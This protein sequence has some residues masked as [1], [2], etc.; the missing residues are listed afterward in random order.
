M[1]FSK[2][3]FFFFLL[4]F[5][6]LSFP[7]ELY[8]R[9]GLDSNNT[10]F[11]SKRKIIVNKDEVVQ[12]LGFFH[13]LVLEP[14]QLS[15]KKDF[16]QSIRKL[17]TK[18]DAKDLR[19]IITAEKQALRDDIGIKFIAGIRESTGNLN[20]YQNSAYAGISWDIAKDGY[21]E[22]RLQSEELTMR[23]SIDAK[24]G[25][26]SKRKLLSLYRQNFVAYY[27]ARQKIPILRKKIKVLDELMRV[28]REGYFYGVELADSLVK[29]ER[30]IEKSKAELRQYKELVYAYCNIERLGFCRYQGHQLPPVLSVKF[31]RVIREM[32]HS[33]TLNEV[34]NLRAGNRIIRLKHDWRHNLKLRAYLYYNTKGDNSFFDKNGLVG[35]VN[36]SYPLSKDHQD[37]DRLRLIHNQNVLE[38]KRVYLENYANLLYREEEEKVS[39]AVKIWYGMDIAFERIR[40][41]SIRLHNE[42]EKGTVNYR[43]YLALVENIKEF[44]DGEYEFVASEELLYRRIANLLTM[45]GVEWKGKLGEVKLTP[46]GNRFRVGNRYVIIKRDDVTKLSKNF[47]ANLLYTKKIEN[48]IMGKNLFD[49]KK[50]R[51]I[52]NA[53]RNF[54]IKVYLLS[55]K[56]SKNLQI[57]I[58]LETENLN[59]ISGKQQCIIFDG[60]S[61][62]TELKR[63]LKKTDILFVP[64][65]DASIASEKLGI[66]IKLN[67]TISELELEKMLD[68]IYHS[69]IKNFLFDFGELLSVYNGGSR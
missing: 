57:P 24:K 20:L 39:D 37:V 16:I 28:K 19:K 38:S 9:Y 6:G 35:G 27:F 67:H 23:Q 31:R 41:E 59:E 54:G 66:I 8:C 42:L 58:C 63:Y 34:K 61:D 14:L 64:Q 5:L 51:A 47:L 52:K 30:E 49:S 43:D 45:T 15:K 40:R 65:K 7:Q 36:I 25:K 29:I 12:A 62:K 10:K 68:G 53:L 32:L 11:D 4:I 56:R 55:N 50:G 2:H 69:G 22:N 33:T 26:L 1:R 48:V 13:R 17:C 44:V 60:N 18:D 3:S 21:L 46:L